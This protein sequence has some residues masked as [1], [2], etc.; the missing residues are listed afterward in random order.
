MSITSPGLKF[1]QKSCVLIV[2]KR[3]IKV[4]YTKFVS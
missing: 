2:T 3:P 4:N 1:Y